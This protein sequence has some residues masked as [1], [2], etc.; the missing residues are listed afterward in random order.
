[1]SERY[2]YQ[3]VKEK[4]RT[5]AL[6][7]G[8][9]GVVCPIMVEELNR[10]G[11][12]QIEM[13]CDERDEFLEIGDVVRGLGLKIVKGVMERRKGQIWAQ[14]IVEAKPQVTRIQVLYSLVELFQHHDTKHDDLLLLL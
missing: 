13:V 9:E 7:V 11:E 3:L 5:W 12:M 8:E 14:F 6:E 2:L 1:M 4:E 10:K